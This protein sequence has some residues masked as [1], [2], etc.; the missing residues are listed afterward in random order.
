MYETNSL[1][2][3]TVSGR[4]RTEPATTLT[5]RNWP[6]RS[7]IRRSVAA[8]SGSFGAAPTSDA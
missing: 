6:R 8:I 5:L 2:G 7:A 1:P 4:L 3:L